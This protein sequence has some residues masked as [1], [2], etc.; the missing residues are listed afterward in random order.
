MIEL[1]DA[2]KQMERMDPVAS[3]GPVAASSVRRFWRADADFQDIPDPRKRRDLVGR[4]PGEVSS[5]P[6]YV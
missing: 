3:W 2:Q 4:Q 6:K 1:K 5:W